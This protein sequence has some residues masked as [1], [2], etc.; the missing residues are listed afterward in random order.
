MSKISSDTLNELI[1]LFE[2]AV[3]ARF[4]YLEERKFENYIY[5]QKIK[6]QK[7]DPIINDLYNVLKRLDPSK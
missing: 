4:E 7:Y 5:A 1:S 6:E 3:D 2:K